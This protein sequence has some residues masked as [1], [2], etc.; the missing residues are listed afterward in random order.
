M[1]NSNKS[2]YKKQQ[3]SEEEN[4]NKIKSLELGQ[5]MKGQMKGQK[6]VQNEVNFLKIGQ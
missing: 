4:K 3:C 5:Q 1:E 2:R 6:N